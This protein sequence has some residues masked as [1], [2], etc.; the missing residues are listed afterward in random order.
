MKRPFLSSAYTYTYIAWA[1]IVIVSV[2]VR[3][4]DD[5]SCETHPFLE[6]YHDVP[7][8]L[9]GRSCHP[10]SDYIKNL[11]S[12]YRESES[13]RDVESDVENDVEEDV[14]S[15]E[16]TKVVCA[17]HFSD[18]MTYLEQRNQRSFRTV[19]VVVVGESQQQQQHAAIANV[20]TTVWMSSFVEASRFALK[21]SEKI[22]EGISVVD[23]VKEPIE[24]G[25]ISLSGETTYPPEAWITMFN[26]EGYQAFCMHVCTSMKSSATLTL[27]QRNSAR[28]ITMVLPPKECY[29]IEEVRS[30]Q[31]SDIVVFN[32]QQQ[33][34]QK[35]RMTTMIDGVRVS[36]NMKGGV[37]TNVH[38]CVTSADADDDASSAGEPTHEKET[39]EKDEKDEKE[40]IPASTMVRVL[41]ECYPIE[42]CGFTTPHL[43]ALRQGVCVWRGASCKHLLRL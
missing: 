16:P 9:I 3:A 29:Q 1:W 6:S 20:H 4:N 32:T 37:L 23:L 41:G 2:A 39:T 33:Q 28:N 43:C 17:R 24:A 22:N 38:R 19:V 8:L 25:T 18:A 10:S 31:E 40:C 26:A 36:N 12:S 27:R 7:V 5:V 13:E 35:H 34:I 11:C 30:N 21:M 14:T 15:F 42:F